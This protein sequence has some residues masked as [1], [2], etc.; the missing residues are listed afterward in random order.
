MLE[1]EKQY[2]QAKVLREQAELEEKQALSKLKKRQN[3]GDILQQVQA[4]ERDKRR[5]EQA[6][7]YEKRAAM[8][9]ELEYQKKIAQAK[10]R[11]ERDV[12]TLKST[13][14]MSNYAVAPKNP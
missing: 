11:T 2:I 8:L 1:E 4:K 10:E 14:G 6:K 9:A 13:K 3:Q 5:E 12:Q 7:M